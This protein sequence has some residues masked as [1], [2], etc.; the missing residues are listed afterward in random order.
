MTDLAGEMG[1]LE[2]SLG[3]SSAD[4]G[5][6]YAAGEEI[7]FSGRVLND[8]DRSVTDLMVFFFYDGDP[9]EGGSAVDVEHLPGVLPGYAAEPATVDIPMSDGSGGCNVGGP[10]G[11]PGI[12]LLFGGTLFVMRG[13]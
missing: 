7:T 10:G 8:S 1:R 4:E 13:R 5:N 2:C 9:D 6:L 3:A 11:F 12:T